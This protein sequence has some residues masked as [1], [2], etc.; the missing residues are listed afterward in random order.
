MPD[1]SR[2]TILAGLLAAP[3]AVPA[4]VAFG[5]SNSLGFRSADLAT[6]GYVKAGRY[7]AGAI[8][9]EGGLP[10]VHLMP[11]AEPLRVW[12]N[13]T[14][15]PALAANLARGTARIAPPAVVRP[16]VEIDETAGE[17]AELEV[18]FVKG[19]VRLGGAP[20]PADRALSTVLDL[21]QTEG[22]SADVLDHDVA[23]YAVPA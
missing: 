9:S 21:A 3:V 6:G 10:V 1:I 4:A 23:T 7:V 11:G 12:V 20:V 5:A 18:D 19:E 13:G 8:G 17:H 2:R 14:E 16:L 22:H 15:A